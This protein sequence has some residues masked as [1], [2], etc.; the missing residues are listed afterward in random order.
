MSEA[1][2]FHTFITSPLI[3]S[4]PLINSLCAC[5]FPATI[6]PKSSSLRLSATSLLAGSPLTTSPFS[7]RSMYHD[8]V[9]PDVFLRVKL[10][11]ALPFLMASARSLEED[12]REAL[13]ASKAMEEGKASA[14]VRC[15]YSS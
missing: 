4:F 6:L 5:V 15:D 1:S 13:M 3:F 12:W 7:F 14:D 11:T 8:C 10:K 2:R 9:S